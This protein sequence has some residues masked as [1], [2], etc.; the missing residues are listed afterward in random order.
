LDLNVHLIRLMLGWFGI[1]RPVL[2]ASSLGLAGKKT[3]RILH[4]CQRVK[5]SC[6]LSGSGGSRGYLDEALMASG[7]VQVA[8]QGF[9]H[10]EYPQR[11][12]ELGFISHLSALDALFNCGASAREMLAAGMES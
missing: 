12:P 2:L 5:A 1:D 8:W 6:Y 9:R 10:P 7:G 4:L 11:Y 3:E